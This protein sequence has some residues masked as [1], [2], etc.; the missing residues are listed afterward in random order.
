[1]SLYLI[2]S[3]RRVSHES[4]GLAL[5]SR[6]QHLRSSSRMTSKPYRSKQLGLNGM[7][8]WAATSALMQTCLI[9]VQ[10]TLSQSILRSST[11]VFLRV[12]RLTLEPP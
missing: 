8:F 12:A 5:I 10:T 9:W 1:M 3:S 11:K 4:A 6:S 7:S 2:I